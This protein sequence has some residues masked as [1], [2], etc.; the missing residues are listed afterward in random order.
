MKLIKRLGYEKTINSISVVNYS[1][2]HTQR[3]KGRSCV[4]EL[5]WSYYLCCK[6]LYC[7]YI[8]IIIITTTLQL[9]PLYVHCYKVLIPLFFP[10]FLSFFLPTLIYP[11]IH[12]FLPL[13]SFLYIPLFFSI[14]AEDLVTIQT[15]TE[16]ESPITT[17]PSTT[18]P[19]HP[20]NTEI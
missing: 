3:Y 13:Y 11:Y 17:L 1:L 5:L 7:Y 4:E 8:I 2:F 16:T 10:F 19:P 18:S 12:S 6:Y 15:T 9:L 20:P 14:T